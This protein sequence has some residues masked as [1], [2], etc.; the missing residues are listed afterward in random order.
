MSGISMCARSKIMSTRIRLRVVLVLG[1]FIFFIIFYAYLKINYSHRKKY[2][3]I[4]IWRG[5]D[6]NKNTKWNGTD[7]IVWF[8]QVTDLHINIYGPKERYRDFEDFCTK[9]IIKMINPHA[10]FVTESKVNFFKS[11]G[12]ISDECRL[13]HDILNRTKVNKHTVWRDLRG[14]HESLDASKVVG[15]DHECYSLGRP[16][17]L[18]KLGY[19]FQTVID[20]DFGS[21]SF[22]GLDL[23]PIPGLLLPMN[24]FGIVDKKTK[25]WA[26]SLSNES[27]RY[28]HTVWMT[29]YPL[30]VLKTTAD[31]RFL[32]RIVSGHIAVIFGH[33]HVNKQ[34][35]ARDPHSGVLLLEL[36]DW[37][38]N[39]RFRI[40]SFDNDL[41]SFRDFNYN[42]NDEPL[43]LITNP[44]SEE[45][46]SANLEPTARIATSTHV[47]A[48][49]FSSLEVIKIVVT[50]DEVVQCDLVPSMYNIDAS[51][52]KNVFSC[53]WNPHQ[54]N[55]DIRHWIKLIVVTS[56]HKVFSEN[57]YFT[58][59]SVPG[60][61][62][63]F[64]TFMLVFNLALLVLFR[65]SIKAKI[66]YFTFVLF[67][68]FVPIFVQIRPD[69]SISRFIYDISE[70]ISPTFSRYFFSV[71]N[72][73]PM[74]IFSILC[75]LYPMGGPLEYIPNKF[76]H[77][78][79]FGTFLD[80]KVYH[81]PVIYFFFIQKV[82]I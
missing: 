40:F 75:W 38:N 82:T 1:I 77:A 11:N 42:Q 22:I 7:N 19:S 2:N 49:I 13:Y 26:S 63:M 39:R 33:L 45:F 61:L 55:P 16:K 48:L 58:L 50:I 67:V 36:G 76:G 21:Y 64:Y 10:V 71:H 5:Q 60:K 4:Q 30:S 34:M 59:N 6:V 62:S 17:D 79:I 37:R 8:V 57:H 12:M 51:Y 20:T 27:Y 35:Y 70:L 68:F 29:H 47:R 78:T 23:A 73:L 31:T 9:Y 65:I 52:F 69:L 81:E 18:N 32:R 15:P 56:N 54:L 66:I 14:N 43:I 28:N 3:P 53:K 74:A 72:Y 46:L 25:K 44:K 80:G 41:F 24:F